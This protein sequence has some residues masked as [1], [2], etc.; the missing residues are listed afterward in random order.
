[1]YSLLSVINDAMLKYTA[2]Q[3]TE[4]FIM[5]K[6]NR[7]RIIPSYIWLKLLILIYYFFKVCFPGILFKVT[8]VKYIYSCTHSFFDWILTS[9]L[10]VFMLWS[11]C[12]HCANL[13]PLLWCF[14][15]CHIKFFFNRHGL[16]GY[17]LQ[18]T[19]MFESKKIFQEFIGVHHHL[20]ISLSTNIKHGWSFH[21]IRVDCMHVYD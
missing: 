14:L 13:C 12:L 16:Y 10:A 2:L 6:Q 3:Q 20:G 17:K 1:M 19:G 15:S 4:I 11:A 9:Y 21:I 8:C 7:M 18:D 5:K